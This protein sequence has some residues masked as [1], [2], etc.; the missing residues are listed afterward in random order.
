MTE[1]KN[2]ENFELTA[3]CK[4]LRLGKQIS[5]CI[6]EMILEL[7]KSSAT[8]RQTLSTFLLQIKDYRIENRQTILRNLACL[9]GNATLENFNFAESELSETYIRE[10]GN[11]AWIDEKKNLLF[12]GD[13]GLGKTHIATALGNEAIARGYTTLFMSAEKLL[14]TLEKAKQENCL[15]EKIKRI[16]CNKLLII[17]ELGYMNEGVKNGA[18]LLH[19]LIS[20]RYQK[21]STIIT[22][23]LG[24]EAW[25]MYL[26]G[27]TQCTKATIDRFMHV[28][29]V[30]VFKGQSY[31]LRKFRGNDILI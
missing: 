28:A 24:F 3:L 26:G 25:P 13:P 21:Y 2:I 27:D 14:K 1:I 29:D 30:V 20:K 4:E 16:N 11:C 17:D 15:E 18:S 23:N 5:A 12:T 9:P 10:L 6:A 22:T 19:A 8:P 7:S 31:R